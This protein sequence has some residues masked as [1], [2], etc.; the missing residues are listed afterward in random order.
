MNRRR[1][2]KDRGSDTSESLNNKASKKAT[3]SIVAEKSDASTQ[4]IYKKYVLGAT[5]E[6]VVLRNDA[7]AQSTFIM[8]DMTQSPEKCQTFLRHQLLSS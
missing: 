4:T 6:T 5:I 8:K 7:K 2:P 1:Q 3:E